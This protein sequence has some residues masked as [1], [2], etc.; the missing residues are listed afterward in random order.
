MFS[1]EGL[2]HAHGPGQGLIAEEVGPGH[3]SILQSIPQGHQD[4]QEEDHYL[5]RGHHSHD[6]QGPK[7]DLLTIAKVVHQEE[8]ARLDIN[9]EL[10]VFKLI[11]SL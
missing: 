2:I 7:A 1:D 8:E 4:H 3:Q 6:T 9:S 10:T 11:C 5:Q